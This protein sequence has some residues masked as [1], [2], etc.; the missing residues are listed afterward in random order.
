MIVRVIIASEIKRDRE[1]K[2][3][4]GAKKIRGSRVSMSMDVK[5]SS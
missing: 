2:L 3:C 1:R 4:Q 5:L